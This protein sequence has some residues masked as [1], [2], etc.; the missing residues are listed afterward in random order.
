[1]QETIHDL[2]AQT[3]ERYSRRYH[4]LGYHVRTLGWGT[5]E[6]QRHRFA[7][8][9]TLVLDLTGAEV[10]DF[11]CGFGD[12]YDFL[13][14]AGVPL[15][16]YLGLD[17]NPDL[18]TEAR[19][20]HAGES[21]TAFAAMDLTEDQDGE[22]FGD[23]GVMLGVLNF[24]WK[25]AYDNEAYSQRLITRAFTRV[26]HALVVDFLSARLS[27]DYPREDFVYYHE[28]T[29]LL[30]FALSLTPDVTLKHDY[31][32]IPQKEFMLL[33]RKPL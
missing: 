25:D 17:I 2:T 14:E 10:V 15:K 30:D 6:Q 12:Y 16:S 21:R 13:Q 19:R 3:V 18:L 20:R 33:L 26:R 28:P 32:P 27:P 7:M 9:L 31:Q 1:M 23:V 4:D 11:G 22:P 29:R 5:T 24:N 8:T